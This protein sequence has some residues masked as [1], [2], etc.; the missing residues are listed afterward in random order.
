MVNG[1]RAF[2][3]TSYAEIK[4]ANPDVPILVRESQ[5]TPARAFVRFGES[6]S[7][8]SLPRLLRGLLVGHGSCLWSLDENLLRVRKGR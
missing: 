3:Q 1:D 4:K 5:G 2:I 6:L 7:C 8:L